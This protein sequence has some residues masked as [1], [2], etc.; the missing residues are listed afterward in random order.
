MHLLISELSYIFHTFLSS[1][2]DNCK[3]LVYT[4]ICYNVY[5]AVE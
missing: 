1:V 2:L 4:H 5:S 3:R